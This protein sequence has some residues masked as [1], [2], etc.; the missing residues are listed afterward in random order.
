MTL[1]WGHSESL[2]DSCEALVMVPPQALVSSVWKLPGLD[3]E[4]RKHILVLSR[5]ETSWALA[6]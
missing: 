6:L 1:T 2:A 3:S 4:V 5:C